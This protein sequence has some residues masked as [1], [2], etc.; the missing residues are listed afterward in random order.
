M[1]HARGVGAG[2]GDC[3]CVSR[4]TDGAQRRAGAALKGE[5]DLCAD[6]GGEEEGGEGHANDRAGHVD[7]PV[8]SERRQAAGRGSTRRCLYLPDLSPCLKLSDLPSLPPLPSLPSLPHLPGRPNSPKEEIEGQHVLALFLGSLLQHLELVRKQPRHNLRPG[9]TCAHEGRDRNG[10]RASRC[11]LRA[12]ICA[13]PRHARGAWRLRP[14]ANGRGGGRGDNGR[15]S[16]TSVV[17]GHRAGDS[18]REK[19]AEGGTH[20]LADTRQQQ[21][22]PKRKDGAGED[23]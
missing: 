10:L 20:G 13:L 6:E 3:S 21:R 7:E 23:A 11:T 4:H 5:G 14:L 15:V 18:V 19:V 22:L 17:A 1:P 2:H 9:A 8:R 16:N 12:S